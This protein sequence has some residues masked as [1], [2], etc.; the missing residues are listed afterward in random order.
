MQADTV[1]TSSSTPTAFLANSSCIMTNYQ[2]EEGGKDYGWQLAVRKSRWMDNASSI[3]LSISRWMRRLVS[4]THEAHE[5]TRHTQ[6]MEKSYSHAVRIDCE[7]CKYIALCTFRM[8]IVLVHA[9]VTLCTFLHACA[10]YRHAHF[11]HE[12]SA[13]P[14]KRKFVHVSSRLC[15]ESQNAGAGAHRSNIVVPC[16]VR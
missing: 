8:R 16:E 4:G 15:E 11:P 9:R 5:S 2:A 6:R 13:F 7:Y 3:A 14:C 1:S 12:N 10:K